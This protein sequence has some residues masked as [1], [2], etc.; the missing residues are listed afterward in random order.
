MKKIL[1]TIIAS[2]ALLSAGPDVSCGS[3]ILIL[4]PAD[5]SFIGMEQ[6]L[7]IG[8]VSDGVN[9]GMVEVSD[10]KKTIGA[11]PI[12]GE[13]FVLKTHLAEGLH[14]IVF[15]VPDG[16]T[17]TLRIFIGK[18]KGYRYH[19][20]TDAASCSACHVEA[21]KGRYRIGP[22]Q[23]EICSK[24]HEPVGNS[25]FVHGP[26]AAGTCTPCHDPHGS[27][28]E[29]FLVATGKEL[30]LTCHDQNF[31]KKHVEKKED[32]QCIKCHDPHGSSKDY[33]LR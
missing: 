15:S 30:C 20:K 33:L 9:A 6:L 21:S 23:A 22:M 19:I 26:V 25:E 1:F 29:N 16:E 24:C 4:A 11:I 13:A 10:N 32:A 3:R 14:E 2:A 8:K 28:H 27:R 31:S 17:R 5:E 7:V 12:R 18:Q